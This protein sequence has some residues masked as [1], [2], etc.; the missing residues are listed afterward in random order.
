M[1]KYIPDSWRCSANAARV[2]SQKYQAIKT[3]VR[4]ISSNFRMNY[5][6]QEDFQQEGMIAAL[7]A[8]DSYTPAR[9]KLEAYIQTVAFNGMAMV[10]CEAA[11]Q[12]RAPKII[13]AN[14][15]KVSALTVLE[16]EI[17]ASNDNIEPELLQKED[18]VA[19]LKARVAGRARIESLK[20]KLTPEA[21]LILQVKLH[22]PMELYVM[23]R[24]LHGRNKL[25]NQAL[26]KYTGMTIS[27]V[28]KALREIRAAVRDTGLADV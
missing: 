16:P 27:R 21:R 14:G 18:A 11:A 3:Q 25:T 22:P 17:H 5:P 10:A 12:R 1:A 7:Y 28:E 2:F 19:L 20:S 9:G 23:A 6:S 13:D 8:I 4:I 15:F 24:N 26:S